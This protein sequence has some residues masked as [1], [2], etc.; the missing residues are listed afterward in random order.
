[1]APT[2]ARPARTLPRVNHPRNTATAS[3]PHPRGPQG[4]WWVL[5]LVSAVMLG[6]AG[7]QPHRRGFSATE[8]RVALVPTAEP[9]SPDD[10]QRI[11]DVQARRRELT[12]DPLPSAFAVSDDAG[13]TESIEVYGLSSMNEATLFTSPGHKPVQA[14]PLELF[15]SRGGF[16]ARTAPALGSV[17]VAPMRNGDAG[18]GDFTRVHESKLR[19]FLTALRRRGFAPLTATEVA[20]GLHPETVTRPVI[21]YA[22][23]PHRE[24]LEVRGTLLRGQGVFLPEA[25]TNGT[26]VRILDTDRWEEMLAKANAATERLPHDPIIVDDAD[27][28]FRFA[29]PRGDA[30]LRRRIALPMDK[31]PRYG[32]TLRVTDEPDAVATFPIRG[33]RPGVWG[34]WLHWPKLSLNTEN[35]TLRVYSEGI[36]EPSV[37]W[38]IP[39]A[40]ATGGWNRLGNWV[41]ASTR[42]LRVEVQAA[43]GGLWFAD[44]ILFEPLQLAEHDPIVDPRTG[45]AEPL[46]LLPPEPPLP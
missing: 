9:L 27:S 35:M 18:A 6:A 8:R 46:K 10:V 21:L 4:G 7:C 13:T 33:L 29:T 30:M 17:L 24:W 34:V 38:T 28:A 40:S 2:M 42:P 37:T 41:A 39:T 43:D 12:L 15:D 36:A 19:F 14:S 44:A 45:Q 32:P 31:L 1:M 22:D 16:E 26:A 11:L 20:S 5:L 23:G 3:Q 25:P